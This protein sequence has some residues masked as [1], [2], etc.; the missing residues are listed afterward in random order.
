MPVI[1][2]PIPD[3][4]AIK[5]A[6]EEI[7]EAALTTNEILIRGSYFRDIAEKTL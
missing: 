3:P 2:P 1:K 6:V 5:P 4:L 7:N